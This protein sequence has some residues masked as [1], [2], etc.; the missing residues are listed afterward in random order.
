MAEINLFQQMKRKHFLPRI[1][2]NSFSAY[3]EKLYGNGKAAK[4]IMK[5]IMSYLNK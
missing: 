2:E 5:N 1:F 4:V 3:L